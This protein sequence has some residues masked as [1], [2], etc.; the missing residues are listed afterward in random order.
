M[1]FN[2]SSDEIKK[3]VS[4][5]LG[6]FQKNDSILL[7]VG[8]NERSIAHKF[9]EYLQAEFPDWNVD[10]EYNRNESLVKT[11][12]GIH[13]CKD[14]RRT[15][16]IY[17]D[18]IVHIRN[19]NENLLVVELKVD[20]DDNCDIEKLKLFTAPNGGYQYF[21]GLFLRFKTESGKPLQRWFFGGRE[22]TF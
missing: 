10:C 12:E 17:P 22:M 7:E 1:P 14:Q 8:V 18:I 5:C 19:T 2:Y 9:A 20:S 6:V 21:H 11:L 16:R 4:I 3:K 15:D 13:R